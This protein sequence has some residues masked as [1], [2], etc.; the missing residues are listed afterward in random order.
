MEAKVSKLINLLPSLTQE[1]LIRHIS[2]EKNK[3]P[4]VY[5]VVHAIQAQIA[6]RTVEEA[7]AVALLAITLGGTNWNYLSEMFSHISSENTK[8]IQSRLRVLLKRRYPDALADWISDNCTQLK[9]HQLQLLRYLDDF[10]TPRPDTILTVSSVVDLSGK[11][12]EFVL[13]T[14]TFL[15]SS[16]AKYFLQCVAACK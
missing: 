10:G 8:V 6:D 5:E 16:K 11:V 7:T 1:M 13:L 2:H 14:D 15:R 12:D 9:E 3:C 4:V